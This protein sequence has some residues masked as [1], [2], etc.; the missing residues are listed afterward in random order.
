MIDLH[1]HSKISDGSLNPNTLISYA[2]KESVSVIALTD[3]DSVDGITEAA[4]A[5]EKEGLIFVPGTELGVAW[6]TGEFHLLGLGLKKIDA[7]LKKV[8]SGLLEGR[9]ERNK[10][11]IE[12]M[13]NDGYTVISGPRTTGDGYYES[14]I[15]GIE[16]NQIEI[17]E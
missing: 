7:S 1:T 6:P 16:G 2:K 11:I 3:H 9:T 12:R 8:L 5:A 4:A 13:R 15:V 14:C 17:T 10:V